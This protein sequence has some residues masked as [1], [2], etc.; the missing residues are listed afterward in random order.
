MTA[1]T[2]ELNMT[3]SLTERDFETGAAIRKLNTLFTAMTNG[4]SGPA[5]FTADFAST[6]LTGTSIGSL[7]N[8]TSPTSNL[9]FLANYESASTSGVGTGSIQLG[10]QTANGQY[11]LAAFHD[12]TI[13]PA[14]IVATLNG[15]STSGMG[16]LCGI[17]NNA[18]STTAILSISGSATQVGTTT[19][20]TA[21]IDG[22]TLTYAG[23]SHALDTSIYSHLTLIVIQPLGGQSPAPITPETFVNNLLVGAA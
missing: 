12:G 5:Q 23:L 10:P 7:N 15:G 21:N 8:G 3:M 22:T 9:G 19:D 4:G 17:I 14:Q 6:V 13:T 20:Y 11:L 18:G 16:A 2:L 1:I